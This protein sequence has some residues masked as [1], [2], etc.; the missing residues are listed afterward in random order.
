MHIDIVNN[1]SIEQL[2]LRS[3][4]ASAGGFGQMLAA[5]QVKADESDKADQARVDQAR[6]A[7][8]Q[9]VASAFMLPML[10]QMRNDPLRSDLFHSGFAE[11][12]FQSQFDTILADRITSGSS[13]PLV[14]SIL[15]YVLRNQ[16][17]PQDR[18]ES[19]PL[20]GERSDT[21]E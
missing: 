19:A 13:F 2:K 9:F 10:E 14:D 12:A 7:A 11:E 3:S 6:K 16:R 8:E 4:S 15:D 1:P 20:T 21:R 17:K 18:I 5:S